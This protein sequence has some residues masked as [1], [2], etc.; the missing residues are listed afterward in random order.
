VVYKNHTNEWF[1]NNFKEGIPSVEE[2]D[3]LFP[4]VNRE[5]KN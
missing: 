3:Y 2:L 1:P 5:E 4:D